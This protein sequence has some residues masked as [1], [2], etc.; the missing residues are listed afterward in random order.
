MARFNHHEVMKS[1]GYC[2]RDNHDAATYCSE[3]GSSEWKAVL[4][5]TPI[6]ANP[7]V[8]PEAMA[9][10]PV[11]T[12]SGSITSIQCRTLKE[13]A[14]VAEQLENADILPILPEEPSEKFPEKSDGD[15]LVQVQV[16]TRALE[17]DKE[18]SESLSFRSDA[19]CAK[20]PLPLGLKIT[21]LCLPAIFII[22]LMIFIVEAGSLRTQGF[23]RKAREWKR[24]FVLG[25]IAWAAVVL[26]VVALAK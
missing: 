5:P 21:A 24:W 11:I 22:G 8:R 7:E 2:G 16:S 1:C 19:H 26:I 6:H 13:A 12:R 18:L 9:S 25:L 23:A 10:D 14:L 4:P 15:Y 17:A 20:Q 3:C